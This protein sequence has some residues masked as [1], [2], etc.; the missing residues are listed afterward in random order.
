MGQVK[1]CIIIL[2]TKSSGSSVLLRL[3][4]QDGYG[5]HISKTRH[6]ENE[7]LYWVKAAA[8]LGLPQVN[9]H[10][11]EIPIRSSRAKK[12]WLSYLN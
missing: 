3:L 11:S 1:K 12:T 5:Q 6:G 7:T 9:M 8:I 4:T 2:S 10:D